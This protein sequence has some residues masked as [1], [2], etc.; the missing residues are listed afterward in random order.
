MVPL[1]IEKPPQAIRLSAEVF[2][3]SLTALG[4]NA[5]KMKVRLMDGDEPRDELKKDDLKKLMRNVDSMF[6]ALSALGLEVRDRTGEPFDYGLPDK[7]VSSSPRAGLT[8]ELIVETI[9]PTIYWQ[10]QIAQ[11]GEVVIATPL[12]KEKDKE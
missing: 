11:T 7:I 5:W 2:T 8:R 12:E 3:K 10:N 4:T 9:R 1:A 6:E